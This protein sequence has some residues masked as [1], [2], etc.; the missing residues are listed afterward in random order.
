MYLHYCTPQTGGNTRERNWNSALCRPSW[1][2]CTLFQSTLAYISSGT[3]FVLLCRLGRFRPSWGEC[4]ETLVSRWFW[5]KADNRFGGLLWSIT[6]LYEEGAMYGAALRDQVFAVQFV[7]QN[8]PGIFVLCRW[9][10]IRR[11][12]TSQKV[13]VQQM[14]HYELHKF[15]LVPDALSLC[16]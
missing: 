5:R 4:S 2:G 10:W 1:V 9:L 7:V 8:D 3:V 6:W 12:P 16:G 13:H 15:F 14:Q 11:E